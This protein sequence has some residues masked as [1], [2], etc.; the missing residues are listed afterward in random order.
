MSSLYLDEQGAVVRTST[1]R[2]VV[3]KD[4][5]TLAELPQ[6]VLD[7]LTIVGNVQISTQALTFLLDSGIPVTF[8]STHGRM[9]GKLVSM[10]SKDVG[11]RLKQFEKFH[12]PAFR[13][14][15]S[16]LVVKA[17]IQNCVTLLQRQARNHPE[18]AIDQSI[19]DIQT[20][21]EKALA[22]GA[23]DSLLGM[24]GSAAA[25]YFRVF[26]GLFRKEFMFTER[27]KRPPKDPVNALLSFGY[28]LLTNELN[29][30]ATVEG[31]DPFVGF[32]HEPEHGRPSLAC[33]L[34][35]EFR[36]V[37]DALALI[38][39][40]K[41]VVA[42]DDFEHRDEGVYLNEKGR[43]KYF[44]QYEH[45]LTT[46]FKQAEKDVTYRKLFRDQA[47]S[48]KAALQNNGTYKP[49]IARD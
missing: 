8:M 36:Y 2:L 16:R 17:K 44:K 22:A 46:E 20:F 12:D 23:I 43:E 3:E 18:L 37:S 40:N 49:Y 11:L 39:V 10:E 1:G 30:A 28:S 48:L 27:T 5:K 13:L 32:F 25:A 33:D 26:G 6:A 29:H 41:A 42:E 9:K 19:E 38:L 34:V 45:R 4:G 15:F 14:E 7:S 31:L 24:E 47:G 21:E 35:E